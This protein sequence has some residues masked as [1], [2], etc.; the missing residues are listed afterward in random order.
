MA[1]ALHDL[2]LPKGT[3]I[4]ISSKNC[5]HWVL[6]DMALTMAGY[7]SVPF[8]ASLT[9][10]QLAEVLE[11]SDCKALFIGKMDHWDKAREEVADKMDVVIRFPHYAGSPKVK[12]G[13]DWDRLVEITN[14]SQ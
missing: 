4:G 12:V 1:T 8:Y 2:G 11:K 10:D 6:A 7:V 13:Y 14:Y 3:H 5:A 9:A